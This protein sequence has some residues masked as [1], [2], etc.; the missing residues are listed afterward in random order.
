V[1]AAFARLPYSRRMISRAETIE[2]VWVIWRCQ[3]RDDISR[4]CDLSVG[5]L[6]I[7][8]PLPPPVGMKAKLD[9]LVEEGQIRAEAVVRHQIPGGGLG[10][11]FTAITD[12]D[13]PRLVALINRVRASS[14]NPRPNSC[15]LS[16]SSTSQRCG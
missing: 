6:F 14:S 16:S 9:F 13:C 4:V 1:S 7:S 15:A 11:K 3:G 8:T 5:G 10:L 12:Q 2:H